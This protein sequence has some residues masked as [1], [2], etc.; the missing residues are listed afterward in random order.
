MYEKYLKIYFSNEEFDKVAP[1]IHEL[2]RKYH[3]IIM[4]EIENKE[5]RY[6]NRKQY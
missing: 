6:D 2:E 1:R 3:H 5:K 4:E